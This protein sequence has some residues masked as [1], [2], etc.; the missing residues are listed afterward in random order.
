MSASDQLAALGIRLSSYSPGEHTSTCPACSAQRKKKTARCLSVLIDAEGWTCFCHHCGFKDGSRENDQSSCRLARRQSNRPRVGGEIW[1]GNR[2]A[3]RQADARGPLSRSRPDPEP[4][5]PR[6]L[7][8]IGA[9]HGSGRSADTAECRLPVGRVSRQ[10]A[11]DHRGG[12]VGFSRHTDSWQAPGGLRPKRR[13]E[14]S[15]PR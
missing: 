9:S 2:G 8:Q 13:P 11:A 1:F 10:P 12:R 6:S 4:Q 3:V 14:G 5:I 7:R 15:E